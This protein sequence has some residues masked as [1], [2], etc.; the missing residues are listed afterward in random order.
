MLN[1]CVP[2]FIFAGPTFASWRQWICSPELHSSTSV[3]RFYLA[4]R[5]A[6]VAVTVIIGGDKW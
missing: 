1:F 5:Y 4:G 2:W 6:F 3:I